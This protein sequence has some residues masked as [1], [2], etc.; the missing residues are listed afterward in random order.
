MTGDAA[1]P[2]EELPPA[3]ELGVARGYGRSVYGLTPSG[4]EVGERPR[5]APRGAR[6]LLPTSEEV[7]HPRPRLVPRG[8]D[9]VVEEVV[10]QDALADL[11][12]VRT[13]RGRD[14]LG[15]LRGG[16]VTC[17]AAQLTDEAQPLRE[18]GVLGR[19]EGGEGTE[20]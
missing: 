20:S 19:R 13:R 2:V 9:Q 16:V 10:T 6:V 5:H 15:V 3:L 18:H 17:G 1:D 14:D 11:R 4:E 7:G 8:V 12:E